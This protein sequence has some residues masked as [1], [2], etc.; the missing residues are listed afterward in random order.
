[1]RH[2]TIYKDPNLYIA[3]PTIAQLA[4]GELLVSFRQA[5]EASAQTARTGKHTHLDT[6]TSV[7]VIRSTDNGETWD[8]ATI[9]IIYDEGLDTGATLTVLSDGAIIAGLNNLWHLVPSARRA[10]IKGNLAW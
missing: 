3:F 1:M 5:S 2:I 4:N 9:T 6:H 8:P 10:E 7:R